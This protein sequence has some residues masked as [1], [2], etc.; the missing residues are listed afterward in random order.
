M[1]AHRIIHLYNEDRV[2]CVRSEGRI[3]ATLVTAVM[4]IVETVVETV[5]VAIVGHVVVTAEN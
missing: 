2:M 5:A 4:T 3:V 1:E